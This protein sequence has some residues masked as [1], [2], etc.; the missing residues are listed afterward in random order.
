M[1]HRAIR[2]ALPGAQV[3]SCAFF[4]VLT[5]G[6]SAPRYAAVG[7]TVGTC[8]TLISTDCERGDAGGCS[9]KKKQNGGG[10]LSAPLRRSSSFTGY[11]TRRRT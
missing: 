1:F 6:A 2:S 5:F 3:P 8:K 4:L 10:C 9:R 7:R 11:P